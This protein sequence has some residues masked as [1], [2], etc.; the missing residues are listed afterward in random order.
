MNDTTIYATAGVATS[1]IGT[2]LQTSEVL[3]IVSLI[4]TIVGAFISFIIVP[5]LNWHREA[6]R[7]GKIDADELKDAVNIVADGV[8]K[9]ADE[10]KKEEKEQVNLVINI[11]R[12]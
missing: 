7:D 11:V 5:L 1:A 3:Q 2:M 8:E 12:E 4:I 6:K 10:T 9:I